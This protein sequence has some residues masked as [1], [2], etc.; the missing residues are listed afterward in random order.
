MGHLLRLVDSA[1]ATVSPGLDESVEVIVTASR[2]EAEEEGLLGTKHLRFVGRLTPQQLE[3]FQHTCRAIIYPTRTESFGYP[4]AE[5]RLAR[6]PVIAPDS[7]RAREVAG[8]VLVPYQRE[9]TG[10]IAEA[11]QEALHTAPGGEQQ[12]PFDPDEYFTW[13]LAMADF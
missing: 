11:M 1:A 3:Q 7:E 6:V 8:P 9:D 5:A 10:S 4:L 12:N 2:R 13:L